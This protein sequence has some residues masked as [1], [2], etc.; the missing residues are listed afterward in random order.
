MEIKKQSKISNIKINLKNS[1]RIKY[2][3]EAMFIYVKTK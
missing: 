3:K 2:V 1:L